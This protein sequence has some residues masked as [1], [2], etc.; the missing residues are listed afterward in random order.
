[1]NRQEFL[2]WS[3][4]RFIYLDGATGSNLQKKGLVPGIC[5]EKWIIDNEEALIELQRSYVEAGTN[6]VYAP[7]FTGNRIKLQ[8]YGLENDIVDINEKLVNISKKA[9]GNRALVAGDLT[10]TGIQLKPVGTMD[11]ENLVD[12]Y[13]EQ[14]TILC[15]AGCDLLVIETM[16]SL[17]ET[18]AAMIAAKEVCDLAVICTLTFEA[19]GR[20]LF[21]TD[22]TTAAIVLDSLGAAAIGANCS[23]GPDKMVDVIAKMAGVTSL[24]IIAKPNAGMPTLDDE[25]NTVYDL[26]PEMFGEEVIKLVNAGATI[27]GGCCGTTPMHIKKLYEAT[28]DLDIPVRTK[29]VG[30]RYLASERKSLIFSLDDS[31][32]VVGERINPTGKKKLQAELKE[33]SM[34]L[35]REYTEQQEEKGAVILDVNVGMGGIDEKE[36]MLKVIDEVT[37][38]TSLPLSI[39]TSPVDVLE[40]GLR[41]Y[42]GRALVNSIS[43]E[44]AFMEPKLRIAK[45]YGAMIILLP[46][47][48]NGLP[49]NFEEKVDN[50]NILLNKAYEY[51]FSK[52]D[53]VVDGLVSTVGA[54]PMAAREVMDMVRYCHDNG[55]ATTCGL[56]NIS[57]GLP[58]RS[59]VNTA[60]LTMLI[61]SGLTMAIMNPSQDLLMNA[62]YASDLLMNKPESSIKYINRMNESEFSI[63][64]QKNIDE[65]KKTAETNEANKNH[66]VL[67]ND[68]LKG[69]I[70]SIEEHTKELLKSGETPENLLN[71]SLMIAI[72]EVGILFNSGKYFLPQLIASAEAMKKSIE[73]L[74]PLFKKDESGA[75]A[76]IVV[77]ATV[78]G[79]IHDIG[80]NLVVMM[81]KNHGFKVIDLGKDV[82]RDVIVEEAIKQKAS[83]IGL[84]ALMTTTMKEMKNVI[85]K[86]REANLDV[87]VM[88]GGAVITE[89]YAREIGA[90][91]YSKDAAEA[92]VVA[93]KLL[94]GYT[95]RA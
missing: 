2:E 7:T 26:V 16:M 72:D 9:V 46:L 50:L 21:G 89:D 24:P 75:D 22:A 84:S 66:T 42:P 90:D 80:K 25:G 44:T 58:E 5:P 29:R 68:V 43:C 1:M 95:L 82:E 38:H 32:M 63:V 34:E 88:V 47:S 28:H 51:G 56:S 91:G 49:K 94:E 83:I 62:Y 8:E 76:P 20:T 71:N 45:K 10:M 81:L 60:F 85:D 4:D 39:D 35:I 59:F 17:N 69:N 93:K 14:I 27:L 15:N 30:V 70:E 13:K 86:V 37:M 31:F 73:I 65:T 6:I 92:V 18:R 87:K 53:I 74:E 79:D 77:M 48:D 3:K 64:S 52:E 41:K 67:Y 19:D 54:N 23:T 12:I 61:S 40:A 55:L 33:G 78:K 57:F 11:F 36:M